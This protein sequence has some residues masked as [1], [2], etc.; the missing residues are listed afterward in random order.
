M[1]TKRPRFVDEKKVVKESG[2]LEK[3]ESRL[4]FEPEVRVYAWS[5]FDNLFKNRAS[6]QAR[7]F[8]NGVEL[9]EKL[10]FLSGT[11]ATRAEG[12]IT[13][14]YQAAAG[15]FLD[16]LIRFLK[17]LHKQK[18]KPD[19]IH[20]FILALK[21]KLFSFTP[22]II[23][24]VPWVDQLTFTART[25]RF[26]E[27]EILV[28]GAM[29]GELAYEVAFANEN[30]AA[31]LLEKI[32]TSSVAT[33]LDYIR[34]L[35][36]L[37]HNAVQNEFWAQEA[38]SRFF[39]ILKKLQF[40]SPFVLV[41]FAAAQALKELED[42][43]RRVTSDDDSDSDED[44]IKPSFE[45]QEKF[46]EESSASGA[47]PNNVVI[48]VPLDA[49]E[50]LI[51]LASDYVA[52][53]DAGGR[54]WKFFAFQGETVTP[55]DGPNLM[56]I[57][58]AVVS[59]RSLAQNPLYIRRYWPRINEFVQEKIAPKISAPGNQRVKDFLNIYNSG[60]TATPSVKELGS[61]ADALEKVYEANKEKATVFSPIPGEVFFEDP[62]ILPYGQEKADE[63]EFVLMQQLHRPEFRNF[64]EKRLGV[65]LGELTLRSQLQLLRFLSTQSSEQF[66]ALEE[67]LGMP[68]LERKVFLESFFAGAENSKYGEALLS[69]AQAWAPQESNAF[70]ADY[71]KIA[72]FA[73]SFTDVVVRILEEKHRKN[74]DRTSFYRSLLRRANGLLLTVEKYATKQNDLTYD[75]LLN[76]LKDES[77][78]FDMETCQESVVAHAVFEIANVVGET[79][80]RSVLDQVAVSASKPEVSQA[81]EQAYALIT[82]VTKDEEAIH[83]LKDFYESKI[84]FEEYKINA[85]VNQRELLF[86]QQ[87]L[88]PEDMVLDDGCGT[89]RLLIPLAEH[90]EV[91]GLDYTKRHVDI[92]RENN[93]SIPVKQGDWKKTGFSDHSFDAIYSLGRNILHEYT[94]T[95]QQAFFAEA[96][97]VLKDKGVLIVDAPNRERG[98]YRE[99]VEGYARVMQ[100]RGIKNFRY[101]TIY[102]SPDGKHFATRYAYSQEDIHQLA[103]D[104][105]F[106][107]EKIY[108]ET[109]PTGAGDEN[110]YYVLRKVGQADQAL[111]TSVDLFDMSLA[112]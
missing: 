89:G 69:V 3:A 29:I 13:P 95:G 16:E 31:R 96:T 111:A 68:G 43:H 11:Q 72:S 41:Q 70:F 39:N 105:G 53:V 76:L 62:T 45:E 48:D 108:T 60:S 84:K 27:A 6:E 40:E 35:S 42:F 22:N 10:A 33:Q 44:E 94:I 34:T 110:V 38:V 64:I 91:V 54:P 4:N 83:D 46:E 100:K 19:D 59:I 25:S 77:T 99:L 88:K 56:S 61:F 86:L 47:V 107:V 7:S 82:P 30:I 50:Q 90:H 75:K 58:R 67:A 81:I 8:Q 24:E 63:E 104:N 79:E 109:L 14:D 2:N 80:V 26:P 87:L 73:A 85:D 49:E 57:N 12:I 103:Q 36:A 106:I 112:A 9:Q 15:F 52:V 55:Y 74:I 23:N 97:R 102:D 20:S 5:Y 78:G 1:S 37:G 18:T 17:D 93:P 51:R 98:G 28:G 21:E 92:I 65:A 32:T 101:G 71:N 66:G